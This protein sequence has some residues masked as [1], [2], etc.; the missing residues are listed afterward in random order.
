MNN[1]KDAP[2]QVLQAGGETVRENFAEG[3]PSCLLLNSFSDSPVT[4]ATTMQST[5]ITQKCVEMT[6]IQDSLNYS[7][8]FLFFLKAFMALSESE[9]VPENYFNWL[10]VQQVEIS[11]ILSH[12]V[13]VCVW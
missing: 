8:C 11:N 6:Q 3:L 5:G 9:V 13:C 2:V 10:S 12:E 1:N 7:S 4:T